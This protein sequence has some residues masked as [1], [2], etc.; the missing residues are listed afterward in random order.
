MGAAGTVTNV[1]FE[2]GDEGRSGVDVDDM[3]EAAMSDDFWL[4]E[5]VGFVDRPEIVYSYADRPESKFNHVT[6]VRPERADISRLVDEVRDR[7]RGSASAWSLHSNSDSERLRDAL[8]EAGWEPGDVHYAYAIRPAG[9]DRDLP[10]D[11]EVR[12]VTGR[13]ELRTLYDIW[14]D[15]FGGAPDLD[16]SDLDNELDLCTGPDRR[17]VRFVAYR[18]GEPAGVGGINVFDDLSFGFIWGAGVRESHRGCGVYTSLLQARADVAAARGLERLGLYARKETSAPIVEAH[19]FRRH[20][21]M[22]NFNADFR[23]DSSEEGD[24]D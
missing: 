21:Y 12:E 4:P 10:D 20:G 2:A 17:V 9:Y 13:D 19:G 15:V 16:D 14:A 3:L 7:H 5:D 8:T 6:S 23:S 1:A 11:V 22:V 18:R 24:G